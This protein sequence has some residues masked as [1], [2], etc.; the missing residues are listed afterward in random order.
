MVPRQSV[1]L[2][3]S[4]LQAA[5]GQLQTRST[6]ASHA[7]G[8]FA[9]RGTI[10][11]SAALPSGSVCKAVGGNCELEAF[12]Q[13]IASD[14]EVLVAISNF[15]LVAWGG[16][17]NTWIEQVQQ[18][19][20]KPWMVLAIDQELYDYLTARNIPVFLIKQEIAEAQQGTGSNHAVSA[21][22][23]GILAEFL[24]LGYSVLLSDV[25]IVTI[26]D[27]F[28]HLYRDRDIEGA[29]LQYLACAHLWFHLQS[30]TPKHDMLLFSQPERRNR[31][32]N[33]RKDNQIRTGLEASIGIRIA[34][35][36]HHNSASKLL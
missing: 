17:L 1:R 4:V 7:N 24:K 14:H 30:M 27:P 29:N 32:N 25:D 5:D 23:F 36:H 28:Q 35:Q 34:Q 10:A 16:M 26:S 11:S 15:K 19:K 13:K 22:K 20:V 8:S 2:Y 21:L 9:A 6:A 33:S 12:L 18:A 31:A 3:D